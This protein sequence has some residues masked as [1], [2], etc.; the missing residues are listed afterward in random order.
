MERE[1]QSCDAVLMVRPAAFGFNPETATTNFFAASAANKSAEVALADFN[2]A[3]ERL[4]SAGVEVVVLEDSIDPAKPDA[5]F[6][7]NWVSFHADGTLALYPMAALSR[8][9]ERRI[10]TL[11]PLLRERGFAVREIIDLSS[12]EESERFLEGTGSLVL[13]RTHR[14]AY[15]ALGPR[16]HREAL[17]EF[18]RRLG[19]SLFAVETADHSGRPIY[20]TNVLLSLGSRFAILCTEVVRPEQRQALTADI[21]ASGRTIIPVDYE[22]MRNFS[23]NV[24]ELRS[25]DGKSL[26]VLSASA[27]ASLRPN[28]LAMLEG[29]GGVLVDVAIP[30]I[31]A[32]GGG[33]LR[34]M[35]AEIHLPRR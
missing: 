7:N 8:R 3:T 35:I 26:V 24:M 21:E 17:A 18:E 6:P 19:Y 15:A 4:T 20:H 12:Y 5:V 31:E 25:E 29:L 1:S 32:V 33:S 9:R 14:R 13:D 30:N 27:K 11:V 28:Q 16:T 2:R 22:Q 34:C 23:C 10:A